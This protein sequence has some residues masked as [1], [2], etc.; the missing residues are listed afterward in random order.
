MFQFKRTKYISLCFY[1]IFSLTLIVLLGLLFPT[2]YFYVNYDVEPTYF[3]N[4]VMTRPLVNW[5]FQKQLFL[6]LI[7]HYTLMTMPILPPQNQYRIRLLLYF[8]RTLENFG[9]GTQILLTLDLEQTYWSAF[10]ANAGLFPGVKDFILQLKSDG[11]VTANITDLTSQIQFR[12]L[13]TLV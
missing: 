13:Y 9:M 6:I 3:S 10:L 7:I 8:Q 1:G 2:P 12:K 11:V 5:K 4:I